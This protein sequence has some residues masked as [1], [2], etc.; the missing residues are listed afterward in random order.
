MVMSVMEGTKVQE[1]TLKW[2]QNTSVGEVERH[3]DSVSVTGSPKTHHLTGSRTYNIK[4]M[5]TK[6]TNSSYYIAVEDE[7]MQVKIRE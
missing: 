3:E 7:D 5:C 1:L 6:P 2:H 4:K